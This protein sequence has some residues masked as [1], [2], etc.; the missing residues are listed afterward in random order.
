VTW[1]QVGVWWQ[2]VRRA[3]R[4]L[5]V[6]LAV[7]GFLAMY[8]P[9]LLLFSVITVTEEERREADGNSVSVEVTSGSAISQS[10]W[11]VA[12]VIAFGPV[13]AGSAW[14]LAGRAVRPINRVRFVAESIEASDLSRRIALEHGPDEVVALAG[15]FDAMLDRL[16]WAADTQRRLMEETSHELRTPLTVLTTNA[17]VLLSHPDPTLEIYR[18]G[19]ERSK[20]A[21]V[22]LRDTIDELLV[23]ARGQARVIDRRPAN[24]AAIVHELV[25]EAQPLAAAKNVGM[26]STGADTVPCALDE[27]T[28]RRAVANL[29]DNAIK[30]APEGSAVEVEVGATSDEATIV[31]TDH[32]PGV[33]AHQQER[34]FERFWRGSSNDRSGPDS[35]GGG[36]GLGLTIARHIARAH[37]GELSITSPGPTGDGCSF[38]LRLRR[39]LHSVDPRWT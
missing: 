5:R 30:H 11:V 23:D 33:P 12:T 14:W 18:Q 8:V 9:V 22:R 15:S 13:A 24:L 26:V 7:L 17:D 21:A 27:P 35:P 3:W 34:I 1:R 36:T 6:Q 28:V 19:L 10:G 20:A 29:L 4:S 2:P 37:G 25:D 39:S 16:E 32:G 31:V 38:E